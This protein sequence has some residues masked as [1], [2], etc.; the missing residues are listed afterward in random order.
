MILK[1]CVTLL[2]STLLSTVNSASPPVLV[3]RASSTA[4]KY[5]IAHFMVRTSEKSP[6]CMFLTSFKV[7]IVP[8]YGVADWKQDISY[9]QDTGI[10]AFAL[11]CAPT[12]VDYYT[13]NQLA[14]AYEAARQMNFK[15]LIS[16]DFA[17]WNSGDTAEITRFMNLYANHTAQLMYNGSAMVS[18]F[19]GDS[20]D[21]AP[22]KASTKSKKLFAIPNHTDPRGSSYQ[23]TQ[24]D[25]VFSWYAW[26]T[27]GNNQPT[28]APM[29]TFWDDIF[30]TS[31]AG[32]PY[33]ARKLFSDLS[34]SIL[35]TL[36][37]L[38]L[39]GFRHILQ[40]RIGFSSVS[41]SLLKDGIR[42]SK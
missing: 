40:T 37:Q 9:A 2:V 29:T 35:L 8:N 10:D 20:F 6:F 41:S 42:F 30:L 16:F 27:S 14:N 28:L 36:L 32:R 12:R 19:V 15:L 7:G 17:Y 3:E 22:V 21:W 1:V 25:G 33:M 11:N 5:V 38:F 18:T 39:H 23:N 34:K 31:L 4:S 24:F 26:P 13:P